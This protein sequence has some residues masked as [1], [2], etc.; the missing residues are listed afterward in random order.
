MT[1]KY[2]HK[3]KLYQGVSRQTLLEY[4]LVIAIWDKDMLKDDEYMA[5][6]S[7]GI[8]NTFRCGASLFPFH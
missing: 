7:K 5:G 6:V 3:Y 8:T 1:H 2:I 4:K